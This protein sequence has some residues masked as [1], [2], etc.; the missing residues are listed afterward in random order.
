M[1]IGLVASRYATALFELARE[2]GL[3]TEVQADVDLLARELSTPAGR[4][5]FDPR[6][7][8]EQVRKALEAL[9]SHMQRLTGNFLRLVLAK[10][11]LD[12][13]AELPDAFRRCLLVER[14]Q[15]EGVVES[16]RPLGQGELAEIAVA[17]K[18][19]LGKEVL[20]T[21]RTNPELIAGVRVLVDNRL[22]DQSALGRLE[23][24]RGKLLKAR[25]S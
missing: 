7:P 14:G 9:A 21:T 10:R 3:L 11:R 24:L 4:A 8:R 20:L 22:I 19:A 1:K 25:V 23:G 5:L 18:S 17:V 12:V 13:L 15:V 2:Q 6:L 16:P